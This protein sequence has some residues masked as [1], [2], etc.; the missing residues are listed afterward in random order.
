MTE[1]KT[2]K[3]KNCISIGSFEIITD[4]KGDVKIK[5]RGKYWFPSDKAIL[6]E[7]I[8][9]MIDDYEERKLKSRRWE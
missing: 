9:K 8:E 7:D 6:I 3:K 2:N 4:S 1:E 5:F